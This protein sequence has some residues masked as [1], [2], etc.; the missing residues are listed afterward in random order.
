VGFD[1]EDIGISLIGPLWWEDFAQVLLGRFCFW[2]F[3]L[4]TWGRAG[5][6]RRLNRNWENFD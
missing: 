5:Q 2:L 4:S 1:A 6:A 3:W